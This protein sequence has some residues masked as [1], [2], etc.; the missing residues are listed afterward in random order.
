MSLLWAVGLSGCEGL[1]GDKKSPAAA[2][3]SP[4]AGRIYIANG[5][6]GSL[7][8]FDQALQT[9]GNIL[10]SRRFPET[11]AGPIGLFLD[12]TSDTLYVAN[13][14]SDAILIYE[15]VST[16][17]LSA[18][19]ANATRVITGPK[20]G[21]DRPYGVTY[22][23]TRQRLYVVNRE[24][25]VSV[26]QKD[27]PEQN[28]LNG[29]IA[30]CRTLI[31]G[32]T[33]LDFPRAV[34]VDTQRDILYISN[35]G[36]N[37]ILVY[38]NA[39]QPTTQRDLPPTRVISS[40]TDASET[41]SMLYNPFG[42]FIDSADDRLY[43]INSGRNQPGILI[44]DNASTRSGAIVPDRVFAGQQT[45]LSNPAGIDLFVEQDRLY[46]VNENNTNNGS[47]A[48]VVYSDFNTKCPLGTHLCNFAPDRAVTGQRTGLANPAGVAYDPQHEIIYVGNSQGNNVLVFALKSDLTPLQFNS[49][50]SGNPE[51]NTLLEQPSA[52]FY[53]K[54][55]DRLYIANFN[56]STAGTPPILVYEQA[57]SRSYLNTPPSW[58]IQG[59]ITNPL[60]GLDI[61]QAR[62]V[63][64]DKRRN[65]LII[66]NGFNNKIFIYNFAQANSA[67]PPAG[68][69]VTLPTGPTT[70]RGFTRGRAMAVD[71]AAG[72]LYVVTDCDT[73]SFSL[74]PAATNVNS[75]V[76]YRY[77]NLDPNTPAD[78]KKSAPDRTIT[79]PSTGLNRPHGVF[80]DTTND[81]LYVTNI[82]YPP[83]SSNNGP[84]AN[85]VLVFDQIST[86]SGNT[87]PDRIISSSPTFAPAEQMDT[88]IAPFV[89]PVT[90]RLYL[91]NWAKDSIF[92]FEKASTRSGPT[93]PD[94][95]VSGTDTL[96]AFSGSANTT[97]ALY[98][99]TTQG[100]ETLFVGEPKNPTPA[101]PPCRGS[102]LI[103]GVQGNT[104]ASGTLSAGAV[105]PL[106]GPAAMALDPV[107][108]I[109]YIANQGDPAQRADDSILIFTNAS[110]AN[111]T[112]P[113]TGT[114]TVTT[115]S[116]EV[117]GTGT[118]FTTALAPGDSIRIGSTAYQIASID[119]DTALTL[120][121]PY[122]GASGTD[123]P[124]SFVPR[125]LCSPI[126]TTCQSAGSQLNNPGGLLVDSDQNRLYLSN[127]G[128][129]CSD[130]AA[131]CNALLVFDD[132]SDLNQNST[133][134]QVITGTALNSP[135]GIALDSARK[136]LYVANNGSHSVLLF[137]NIDQLN[138]AVTPDAEIGGA[139]TQINAPIGV[140]YDASRDLLYVL[141]SGNT[142]ILVF[143]QAS[144]L[145]GNVAPTRILSNGFMKTPTAFFLDPQ[146]DL[147][148]VAD[149]DNNAVYTFT[150]ASSAAGE[151]SHST[152]SGN[153]TG[154]NQP[155]AVFV[156]TTR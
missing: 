61:Q 151:A 71:E 14:D 126:G 30:P 93:R 68:N 109:L 39:S 72:E 127:A 62:G 35:L 21:L 102:F 10:P 87:A 108:D 124:A 86:R 16:L 130:P 91:I 11:V 118:A 2:P 121:A 148:Y 59:G 90:D 107:R 27:C 43:V 150:T 134:S 56:A 105:S 37:S 76:I 66:L 89:D 154:L 29:D 137:K 99:D 63:Y 18:G 33:L 83:P 146:Q 26:F 135:R 32:S 84:T 129:D 5:G 110:Q 78:P 31:G 4:K 155:A 144:S 139:A 13:T 133:P 116:A 106:T 41:D 143:S 28:N 128:T 20:T 111:G 79:G 97:G 95:I 114:V 57:S 34:T 22:D 82:S 38:E 125:M 85:S 152:T 81:R 55:L 15:N 58:T 3:S 53:D 136:T 65:L 64:V 104:P 8:T 47:T 50:T 98:V 138:G 12:R 73:G 101:C 25:L 115:G 123:L 46:V 17:D 67:T 74:C 60:E 36:T 45:Q 77:D 24:N 48:L 117:A 70:F 153:N 80:L 100:K 88:P 131:P 147:L 7:V 92:V 145:N 51:L 119:S 54:P 75:I 23:P 112:L 44:Y 19:P 49:G 120:T 122:T 42:L 69:A 94:R 52:F 103:F 113:I 40:H 6:D 9:Q 1:S 149:R 140:A 156:D 141:N 142:E 96:L 132:A